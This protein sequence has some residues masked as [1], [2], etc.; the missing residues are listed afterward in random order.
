MLNVKLNFLCGQV[1]KDLAENLLK[2]CQAYLIHLKSS[3]T[4]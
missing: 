1:D 2:G 4:M 3:S